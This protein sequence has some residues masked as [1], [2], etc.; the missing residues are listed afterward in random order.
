M[1]CVNSVSVYPNSITLKV[2]SWSYVASATVCP[3]N[4]DCKQVQWHSDDT[5][6][7]SVNTYS[8]YIY[9]NGVGTT[10]IY[11][12]ATDGSGCSDYLTV[13]VSNTVPVT[14]VTLNRSSLSIEKGQSASLSAT[15]CPDNATNKNVNWTSSNNGVATVSNGVVTAVTN[16]YARITATAADGSGK[17]ASCT[18]TVTGNVLV[19][20]ITINPSEKILTQG[21]SAFLNALV[22]P[23][24][25]TKKSVCW[26]SDNSSIVT[27]NANSGL[28]ISQNPGTAKVYATACDGSGAQGYCTVIVEEPIKVERVCISPQKTVVTVGEEELLIASISPLYVTD[29]SVTWESSNKNV[30]TVEKRI[31]AH[32]TGNIAAVIGRSKGTATITATANDG[33]GKKGSCTVTVDPREK[34]TVRKDGDYFTVTFKDGKVWKSVGRDLSLDE[35]TSGNLGYG[36]LEWDNLY[37]WEQ[38]FLDNLQN[39]Y[40]EDQL[41]YIYY[42]DPLGVEDYMVN[43]GAPIYNNKTKLERLKS[44]DSLY[45]KIFGII[46]NKFYFNEDGEYYDYQD[47]Q[48]W[49]R[50]KYY[51]NAE[52]LFGWHRVPF[53]W[54]RV[55]KAGLSTLF[56]LAI[57]SIP[58]I[59]YIQNGIMLYKYAFYGASI[60]EFSTSLLTSYFE[61]YEA[62][63]IVWTISLVSA[64]SDATFSQFEIPND[65]TVDVYHKVESLENYRTV[66]IIGGSEVSMNDVITHC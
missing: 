29:G 30:A 44:K 11:A 28:I 37:K 24:N 60:N 5:S 57:G 4:A 8:G 18:V 61:L 64:L 56:E 6:V 23:S 10:R 14:S 46:P 22:Y 40:T 15:V 17:S 21:E 34:V 25:A 59:S 62:N 48:G 35:N 66:F 33:S 50:L 49:D 16:G 41:A 2:G 47:H 43:A 1:I 45:N 12:T 58:P 3:S 19:S 9:A 31:P 38:R 55:L 13:T 42:F 65:M 53:D 32:G 54:G 51:S 27:V 20:S 52:I 26:H 36:Y 7:A 63:P 39:N